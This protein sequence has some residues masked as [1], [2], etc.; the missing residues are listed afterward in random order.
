MSDDST[1]PTRP[2]DTDPAPPTPPADDED[3]S[4]DE[5][6][7]SSPDRADED[8]DEAANETPEPIDL[9]QPLFRESPLRPEGGEAPPMW[10]WMIIFGVMLFSVFYL[11]NYVG[12]FSPD[13]WLQSPDPVA[14]A[15]AAPE[16][17]TVSGASIYSARCANCHQGNGEGV[18]NAFPPLNRARWVEDKGQ[19]IRILLH[20]MQGPVEVRGNNYNGNMPAW[21]SVL[22]DKEIAA[23]ITHVRQNWE[24][25][26]SD[27]TAEEVSSVRSATEGRAQP[28]TAAE[29]DEDGNRTVPAAGD[30][31]TAS[32]ASSLGRQLYAQFA[33]ASLD[34]PSALD[35]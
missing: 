32:A 12:D 23:V 22:S 20:G 27:V 28:W 5:P 35:R 4:P 11:G 7:A 33:A 14:Q 21:G 16:E 25:D 8:A 34:T 26:F 31:P 18:P 2:D 9:L 1:E 3:A 13:P 15:T 10:L 19:I 17:E 24:N 29:L 6:D 30:E